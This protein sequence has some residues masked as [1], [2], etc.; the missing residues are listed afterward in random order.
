MSSDIY[1]GL[2]ISGVNYESLVD[3]EGVR[4]AI[5]LSGCPHHCK[6]CH[7]PHT[8]NAAAGDPVT[9]EL[10]CEIAAEIAKRKSFLSGITFTGGDPFHNPVGF[11]IFERDLRYELLWRGAGDLAFSPTWFYTGYT[12]PDLGRTINLR[13]FTS[14]GDVIVDGRFDETLADRTLKFRGSSNQHIY[15]CDRF[16]GQTQEWRNTETGE[17]IVIPVTFP[18]YK[19]MADAGKD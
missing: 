6:G 18:L 9:P 7:N 15:V 5:Y 13:C 10:I 17:R 4:A 12:L 2:H 14:K 19:F 11:E 8:W 3:G 16:E 1:N